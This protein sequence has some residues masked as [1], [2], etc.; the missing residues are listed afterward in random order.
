MG[1]RR[2]RGFTLI[3]LLVVI[4]IIGVLIGL[5][6]PAVQAARRAARK[7]QCA[8]NMHNLAIALQGSLNT[9]GYYPVAGAFREPTTPCSTGLGCCIT[10]PSV[11]NGCFPTPSG[12]DFWKPCYGDSGP[13]YSWVVE[14]LPYLDAQDL[15]N[16]WN[17][18]HIYTSA[19]PNPG[20]Q[21]SN[22]AIAS[23]TIGV[24]VCPDDLTAQPGAG[25]LSYVAN[26]GFSRWWFMPNYGWSSGQSSG[27][28]TTS[29]APWGP[30]IAGRM[31]VMFL[32]S[33]N[34]HAPWD[35]KTTPTAIVDGSSQT[36]LLSENVLAGASSGYRI[37]NGPNTSGLVTNWACPHPNAIMF[38]GS[39]KV[40][41]GS[42]VPSPASGTDGPGWSF[43]NSKALNPLESINYG[44]YNVATEGAFPF[45]SS[46][47]SGGVNA[48]FC[49][50][51]VRFINDTING[52]VYA[53]L[54]T[55]GGSI[56]P[57]GM[58][59]MPLSSD[60]Y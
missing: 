10:P 45:A 32:G 46:F 48:V 58:R 7:S 39:D 8:S 41:G 30:D 53:K 36:L 56:L 25:N 21:P 43:A 50:G 5:L 19:M 22:A 51:S 3:E 13:M 20:A 16:A 55:P 47:H 29:G 6:L 23:K 27:P 4:S 40:A 59:Q 17:K 35:H 42:L 15:A 52:T 2:T 26:G 34:G 38:I 9:R 44:T 31:G 12:T 49:D 57:P 60:E 28:D 24:L 33:D 14:I 54:L 11:I 1:T 37:Q 18:E